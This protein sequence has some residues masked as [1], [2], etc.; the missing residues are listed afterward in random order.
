MSSSH[1]GKMIAPA[2]ERLSN[3]YTN[4]V[5]LKADVDEL[6]ETAMNAGESNLNNIT[7]DSHHSFNNI[8]RRCHGYANLHV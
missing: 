8:C 7:S 6:S 3:K 5:F 2:Y 1:I 4:L